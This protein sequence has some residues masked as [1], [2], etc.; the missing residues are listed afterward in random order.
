MTLSADS[1]SRISTPN[2]LLSESVFL[3]PKARDIDMKGAWLEAA[4]SVLSCLFVL[5]PC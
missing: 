5:T 4:G 2:V 1:S 3:A